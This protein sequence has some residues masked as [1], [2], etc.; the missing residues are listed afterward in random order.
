MTDTCRHIHEHIVLY[1]G[2]AWLR[3]HIHQSYHY[4]YQIVSERSCFLS[5]RRVLHFA[6]LHE[7]RFMKQALG[8]S[9]ARCSQP[10]FLNAAAAAL[11]LDWWAG[12]QAAINVYFFQSV[13]KSKVCGGRRENSQNSSPWPKQCLI[14]T[15]TVSP[16]FQ[17]SHQD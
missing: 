11:L 3:M 16:T 6:L 10:Y 5:F 9:P 7:P 17:A 4:G 13:S 2:R 14:L 8:S 12:R 1:S 15:P